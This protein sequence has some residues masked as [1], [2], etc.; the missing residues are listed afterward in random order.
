MSSW[1]AP[2]SLRARALGEALRHADYL[3]RSPA[4]LGGLGA[5]GLVGAGVAPKFAAD[6][7]GAAP[8]S[9]GD[10]ADAQALKTKAGQGDALIG[11]QL[12]VS[13]R[14]RCNLP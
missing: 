4:A 14:H 8:Q 7:A 6:G 9:A 2:G 13:R 3:R 12:L 10:G 5:V 1:A 11:A